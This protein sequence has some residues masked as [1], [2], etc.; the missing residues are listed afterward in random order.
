MDSVIV[1]VVDDFI[2]WR[3]IVCSMLKTELNFKN[4]QEAS[5]GVE[6]VQRAKEY[7]PDLVL[8]DI[9]LPG[10][11]GIEAARQI[12]NVAPSSRI[13]ILS[14]NRDPD[15]VCEALRTAASGYVCKSDAAK[16]LLPAVE[17]VLSGKRYVSR[18]LLSNSQTSEFEQSKAAE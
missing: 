8:L 18:I 4:I 3:Q 10:M 6:A 15:V 2:P 1:L 14:E 11:N 5:D 7:Q 16:E 12:H 13:L 9:A 17:A